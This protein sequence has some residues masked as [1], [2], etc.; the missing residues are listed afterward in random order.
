M[1]ARRRY[2]RILGI[3]LAFPLLWLCLTG[4]VL[5]HSAELNLDRRYLK[6]SFLTS[7]YLEAPSAEGKTAS[8]GSRTISQWGDHLFLDAALLPFS[9]E[10]VGAVALGPNLLI[11]TNEHL[12]LLGPQGDLIDSLDEASLPG[13]PIE[14]LQ[15]KPLRLL[16]TREGVFE[17]DEELLEFRPRDSADLATVALSALTQERRGDLQKTLAA[18]TPVSYNRVLLDLHK[19]AFLG[20]FGKWVLT[21][22]TVA[23]LVLVFTGLALSRKKRT[24]L[25]S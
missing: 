2:H 20:S 23:L 22:S 12:Y 8:V 5:N 19:F 10:L 15:A 14:A 25:S 7:F 3:V 11:A 13:L 4:I 24:K 16:K 18:E 1:R 9:G 6:S 21:L 17:F